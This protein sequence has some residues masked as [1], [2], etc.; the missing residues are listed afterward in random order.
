[1]NDL[2]NAL[3]KFLQEK[4]SNKPLNTKI[5]NKEYSIH[6]RSEEIKKIL[7]KRKKIIFNELFDV[8]TKEYIIIT[9][10]S[11]L[12]M[13]RKQEIIIEQD[14]NFNNIIIKEKGVK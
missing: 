10:I 7:K 12:N 6:K 4:E 5:T 8:A 9:F 11:I 1:M 14:N 2:V 13:S 3:N